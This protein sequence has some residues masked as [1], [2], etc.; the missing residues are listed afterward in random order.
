MACA[1]G[2]RMA[3]WPLL[4]GLAA[5]LGLALLALHTLVWILTHSD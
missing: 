4:A 2:G 3:A 5:V 1:P